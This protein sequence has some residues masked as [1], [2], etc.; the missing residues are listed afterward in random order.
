MHF[1][2]GFPCSKAFPSIK[3]ALNNYRNTLRESVGRGLQTN[4]LASIMATPVV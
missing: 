2:N 3:E 4:L 1:S